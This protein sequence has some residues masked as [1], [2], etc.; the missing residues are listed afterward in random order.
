MHASG[1]FDTYPLN[2]ANSM[3]P[4]VVAALICLLMTGVMQSHFATAVDKICR[5]LDASHAEPLLILQLEVQT[6]VSGT[7]VRGALIC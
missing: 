5:R 3:G 6:Y 4:T 1:S 2:L 7:P